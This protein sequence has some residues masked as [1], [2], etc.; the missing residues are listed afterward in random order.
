M[1]SHVA[2]KFLLS[3]SKQEGMTVPVAGC[4]MWSYD[5]GYAMFYYWISR[6]CV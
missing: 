6:G 3:E 4:D 5:G 2:N 1:G